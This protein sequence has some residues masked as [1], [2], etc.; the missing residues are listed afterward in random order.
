[1]NLSFLHPAA[2]AA[3]PLAAA[4]WLLHRWS[5]S[6]A[7][8]RP[9]PTLELLRAALRASFSSSVLSH[10]LLLVLRTLFVLLLV[11]LLSRPVLRWGGA[12]PASGGLHVVLA[13]DLSAS[14]G[15]RVAGRSRLAWALDEAKSFRPGTPGIAG[16]S[17]VSFS[18]RVE[19]SF[20]SFQDAARFDDTLGNLRLTA[21]PT[22][23]EAAFSGV[24]ALPMP[25]E[26]ARVLVLLTDGAEN[27]WRG[28]Q[29]DPSLF[30]RVVVARA[31]RLEG[32]AGLTAVSLA[33][34]SREGRLE[35]AGWGV[36]PGDRG[37]TV[38]WEGRPTAQGRLRLGRETAG[39]SFPS[40]AAPPLSRG[41]A[42]LDP[43]GYAADD[44][45][46]LLP[47]AQARVAVLVVNGAPALAPTA[48]ETY[49]LAPVLEGLAKDGGRFKIVSPEGLGGED[50][51][52]WNV[53]L[54][55]NVGSLSPALAAQVRAFVERGGGVWITA[56]D[57]FSPRPFG[58]LLP[59]EPTGALIQD[60]GVAKP[61]DD[62]FRGADFAWENLTVAKFVEAVPMSG[63][64]PALTA[65]P[66]GR[67]LLVLGRFARGRTAFLATSLDRDW[68][69]LPSRPL[70]P[71]LC[72]RILSHLAGADDDRDAALRID[73]PWEGP[74]TAG[75]P[76]VER[77]DG[78]LA[79]AAVQAG[80]FR[81]EHTDAPGFYTLRQ[82]GAGDIL[83]RAAV[84][85][86]RAS[87]EGDPA[88]ADPAAFGEGAAFVDAPASVLDFVRERE[89]GR[90]LSGVLAALI[91]FLF[92][93]ETFLLGWMK[94]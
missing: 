89:G 11:L 38:S 78:V 73:D 34:P 57:R 35:A 20:P 48:D 29:P 6:K 46:Y 16:V 40:S 8:K 44:V 92:A 17:L 69:N 2:L 64:T 43:D 65:R 14:M 77:P 80:R 75:V 23:V 39:A 88:L 62:L 13:V 45:F 84:N 82:K 7:V 83:A 51:S 33:G 19:S 50:L 72:R 52:A 67:P 26:G 3:L 56:G 9:F 28:A 71:V 36:V 32:N 86:D 59:A 91:A 94:R 93:L 47:P 41:E 55:A 81:F 42:A 61:S 22:R 12:A 10:R 87:G 90:P 70:F 79:E 15:A 85:V 18:D 31:P 25:K 63:A 54:F 5:L 24:A 4:P 74:W 66:S 53:L 76:Q 30:S 1:M 60:S 21:R 37:W 49:F 68:N 27:G 58:S